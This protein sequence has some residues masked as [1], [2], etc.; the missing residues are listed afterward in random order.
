[1]KS[2]SY[3]KGIV[4]MTKRRFCSH[5]YNDEITMHGYRALTFAMCTTILTVELAV[6]SGLE[7]SL[8]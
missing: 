1:V 7:S 3:T 5:P 2:G 4:R 8:D 6:T